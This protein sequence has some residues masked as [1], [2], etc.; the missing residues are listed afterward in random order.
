METTRLSSKGQVIIPQAI[1]DAHQWQPG[2][3]F[4]VIEI[5]EGILLKPA[6]AFKTSSVQEVLGCT[7]YSGKKKSLEEMEQGIAQGVK[8][9]HD[10]N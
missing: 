5:E 6:K 2:L 8:Q 7:G 9:H 3:A 1:R 10:S 4:T